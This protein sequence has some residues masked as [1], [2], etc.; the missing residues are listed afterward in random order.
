MVNAETHRANDGPSATWHRTEGRLN[1]AAPA[2]SGAICRAT[3]AIVE[4]E[5]ISYPPATHSVSQANA[6]AELCERAKS[7][8]LR[9]WAEEARELLWD[10]DFSEVLDWSTPPFARWFVGGTINVSANCIDRHVA[11]GNG[12]RVAIHWVGEPGDSRDI[13]YGELLT[14]VGRAANYF[15]EVGL[16]PGDRVAIFMPL[17]PEAIVGMLACAR[18]GLVHVAFSV[19]LSSPALRSRMDDARPKVVITTDGQYCRG[20]PTPLKAIVDDALAAGGTPCRSVETVVVARRTGHDVESNWTDGRDVWWEDTVGAAPAQ[21]EAQPFPAEHPLFLLYD[22]RSAGKPDGFVHSSGGYLTQARYTFHHV[23]DHEEG[24]DIFWCAA[25]LGC[26]AGHTYLVYGPLS[27]GAT[28]VIYEGG[29]DFPDAHRPFRIIEKYG[30]TIFYIA[31]PLIRTFMKWGR[32]VPDAQD[33]SSLRLL[34][35]LNERGDSEAWRWYRDVIGGDRCPIVD[36]W[37]QAE[38]GAI[39]IAPLPGVTPARPGSPISPLPGISAHIVDC[40]T[41]LV[42]PGER[43]SLV[44]DRPWPAMPRG[45]WGDDPRF[46]EAHWTQFAGRFWYYTGVVAHYDDEDGIWLLGIDDAA[47]SAFGDHSSTVTVES[48]HA[49]RLGLAEAGVVDAAGEATEQVTVSIRRP[50]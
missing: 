17:I 6:S 14:D 12:D 25:D 11:A 47:T 15:A 19:G 38:T 43:G 48:T 20:V 3:T 9:F 33:L 23:F 30:V 16:R 31:T 46:V 5:W 35:T 28:S 37:W 49:G 10:S 29:A 45:V 27:D 36:T 42:A 2:G 44:L 1:G 21:H 41:D 18:L 39:M 4:P 7:N 26:M 50:A 22:T 40:D 24:S 8:R 32:D 13:T 34:G